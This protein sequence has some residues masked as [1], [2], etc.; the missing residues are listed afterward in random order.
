MKHES[1]SR[2]L[3]LLKFIEMRKS[4]SLNIGSNWTVFKLKKFICFAIKESNQVDSITLVFTGKNLSNEEELISELIK[5]QKLPQ[6]FVFLK[7]K[8]GQPRKGSTS[9]SI[10]GKTKTEKQLQPPEIVK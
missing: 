5:G 6:F 10:L 9:S 3:I 4:I 8:I 7:K 1:P 2:I